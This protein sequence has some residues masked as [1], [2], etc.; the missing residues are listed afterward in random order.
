M[1]QEMQRECEDTL[2]AARCSKDCPAY[3]EEN[4]ECCLAGRP[5]FWR[6]YA[7]KKTRKSTQ[8]GGNRN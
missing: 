3:D 5:M 1:L 2:L 4:G 7:I 8:R 6:T